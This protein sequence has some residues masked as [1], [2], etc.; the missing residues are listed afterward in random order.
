MRVNVCIL[1][2]LYNYLLINTMIVE[3][4]DPKRRAER[5]KVNDSNNAQPGG[6]LL[7]FVQYRR[8]TLTLTHVKGNF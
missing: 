3:V 8:G 7:N 2:Y 5:V 4:S 6:D 1:Q